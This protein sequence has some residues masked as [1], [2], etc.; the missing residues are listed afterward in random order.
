MNLINDQWLPV[1]RRSGRRER[2]APW[3]LT[4]GHDSDPVTALDAARPDFQGALAQ[5]LIGLLQTAAAPDAQRGIDWDEWLEAPPSPQQL[6]ELVGPYVDYFELG[7]EGPRFLQDFDELDDD[8][9]PIA[10]LLIE[11]PGANTLRNNTDHFIK[12]G[13]VNHICPAC[14]AAALFTLQT[15]APGGGAGHRTSL[16]G[17]GPLTTLVVL[18]P[19]GEKVA[20]TLWRDLWLNILP[21]SHICQLTGNSERAEPAAIFPWLAPTR[22]SG[23]GGEDT[24]PEHAHPLQMY[25]GM[26]RRIRLELEAPVE[27]ECDICSTAS[28][29]LL[30]RY[31]TKNYGI[32]YSG[33]WEH[34]LTPHYIDEKSGM[35]MPNHAQPGGFSFRHW[36]GW[37]TPGEARKPAQ[38]VS[39]FHEHRRMDNAQLR[40]WSSGYDMDNMKARAWYETTVPLYLLPEGEGRRRFIRQVDNLID[41]ATQAAYYTR[42][43]VKEAWFS[44]P[45]DAKGDT[46][47]IR[48]E[49]M[50][51]TEEAFYTLLR[52]SHEVALNG[53]DEVP[54]RERWLQRLRSEAERLFE[55]RAE[56]GALDEGELARI[57]RAHIDLRKRLKGNKLYELLGLSKPKKVKTMGVK[58]TANAD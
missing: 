4:D 49:F 52:E 21:Q 37:I 29:T 30:S 14:A 20:A 40:L 55:E 36:S 9:K 42:S 25:W 46:S 38:V 8:P 22:I 19:K 10:S 39:Y 56:S 16:R 7:G 44:R 43:A 11:I 23:K 28:E 48:H 58:E 1:R 26:P 51:R 53:G 45:G 32:N 6:Q 31:V 18:D 34:P 35:P 47:F 24:L 17:G 2:I 33:A 5:F 15:S 12:R 41:A 57:A 13:G 27:G 50:V 3:E 54:L